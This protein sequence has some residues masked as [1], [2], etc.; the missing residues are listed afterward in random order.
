MY[1]VFLS[2][3]GQNRLFMEQLS[4]ALRERGL[5]AF[6]DSG[7]ASGRGISAEIETALQESRAFFAYYS[8]GYPERD[9]CQE[10]LMAALLSAI[11]ERNLDRIIVTNPED[12]DS[13]H[14]VPPKLADAMYTVRPGSQRDVH[15]L[16]DEILRRLDG[17]HG[18]FHDLGFG[19]ARTHWSGPGHDVTGFVGRYREKWNL[20]SLLHESDT[21][22]TGNTERWPVAVLTGPPGSGKTALAASYALRFGDVY[23][24]GITWIELKPE[25]PRPH[26]VLDAYAAQARSELGITLPP[27]SPGLWPGIMRKHLSV[28]GEQCLVVVD[29]LPEGLSSDTASYL[30][31]GSPHVKTLLI[32]QGM[33]RSGYA[34]VV[35][36]GPLRGSDTERLLRRCRQPSDHDDVAAMREVVLASAGHARIVAALRDGLRPGTGVFNDYT[37]CLKALSDGVGYFKAETDAVL[38]RLTELDPDQALVLRL[39]LIAAPVALPA[40]LVADVLRE[41]TRAQDRSAKVRAIEALN[42]LRERTLAHCDHGGWWTVSRAAALTTRDQEAG[43]ATER[44]IAASV[45]RALIERFPGG[46][47]GKSDRDEATCLG[48]HA[49]R[50]VLRSDITDELRASLRRCLVDHY[51]SRGLAGLEAQVREELLTDSSSVLDLAETSRA[52]LDA[53]SSDRAL[54]RATEALQRSSLGADGQ[55]CAISAEAVLAEALD[56]QGRFS[57]ADVHWESL[58]SEQRLSSLAPVEQGKV[59]VRCAGSHRVR[60]RPREAWKVLDRVPAILD[61]ATPSAGTRDLLQMLRVESARLHLVRQEQ[62]RARTLSLA[63]VDHY[64]ARGMDDHV[65]ANQARMVWSRARLVPGLLELKDDRRQW[66]EATRSLRTQLRVYREEYGA[67]SWTTISVAMAYAESLVNLGWDEAAR[68]KITVLLDDLHLW[69]G[70]S[71]PCTLRATF[72]LGQAIAQDKACPDDPCPLFEKAYDGQR[73]LL[74]E[75]NVDTLESRYQLVVGLKRRNRPGDADR[76]REIGRGLTRNIREA[77][78]WFNDLHFQAHTARAFSAS[79][80]PVAE[81]ASDAEK[82]L[83]RRMNRW[84]KRKKQ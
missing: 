15:V 30:V 45:A 23:R 76:A 41:T 16:A 59:L 8:Y 42:A 40:S 7:I 65:L 58:Y 83:R 73:R 14:I 74:G 13:S 47:V 70:A 52:H 66:E 57:E 67:D 1:D 69:L 79:M 28:D 71:H 26:T 84:F 21:P 18:T 62:K 56:R 80:V 39:A 68:K 81:Y 60:A 6:V 4:S 5:H 63:V 75:M 64:G 10:E 32:T 43:S 37:D 48:Q 2:F 38:S 55:A 54:S 33:P 61:T 12:P 44:R 72:L 31:C 53:G 24:G 36:L 49:H 34:P 35:E 46:H 22:L 25:G 20:Y 17:I 19:F 82:A 50:L 78:G 9:A 27:G 29:G 51:A 3:S 77:R 11:R